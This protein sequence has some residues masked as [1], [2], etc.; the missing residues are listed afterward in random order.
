[1]K[2]TKN[3]KEAI[4]QICK[5]YDFEDAKEIRAWLRENYGDKF[6]G[7]WFRG[8]SV[9]DCYCELARAVAGPLWSK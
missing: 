4:K 3:Q 7:D 6:D 9:K 8:E 2:F 5:E 1:M